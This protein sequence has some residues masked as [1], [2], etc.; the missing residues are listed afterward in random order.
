MNAQTET[1]VVPLTKA[2]KARTIFTEMHGQEGVARKDVIARIMLDCDLSKPAA[3]TYYQNAK[4][5]A[6]LVN[7]KVVAEQQPT[8]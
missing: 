2:D 5:K 8:E 4:A 7:H 1:K 3:A 6:G